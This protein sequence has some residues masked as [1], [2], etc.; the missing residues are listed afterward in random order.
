MILILNFFL[1]DRM[2][3][4]LQRMNYVSKNDK[5]DSVNFM[6]ERGLINDMWIILEGTLNN[7]ILPRNLLLFL[8]GIMGL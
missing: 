1:F 3:D 4:I 8:L 6:I 5:I 7:G 2:S